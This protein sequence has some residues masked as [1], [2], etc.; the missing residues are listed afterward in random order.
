MWGERWKE[1][2]LIFEVGMFEMMGNNEIE[3]FELGGK[4]V[5][6]QK[7][8]LRRNSGLV[9]IQILNKLFKSSLEFR[10]KL[11]F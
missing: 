2:F 6:H 9:E 4:D 8:K 5:D 11:E 10:R 7:H 1:G 3:M